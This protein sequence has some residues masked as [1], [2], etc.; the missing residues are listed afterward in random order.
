MI[1]QEQAESTNRVSGNLSALVVKK[2]RQTNA[3]SL[4]GQF[5]TWLAECWYIIM[6]LTLS[7]IAEAETAREL[8]TIFR[9][10]QFAIIPA[11]EIVTSP[12]LKRYISSFFK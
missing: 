10:L 2:R 9:I 4:L 7:L 11:I 5:F 6:A 3:I 8:G 1:F 12:P